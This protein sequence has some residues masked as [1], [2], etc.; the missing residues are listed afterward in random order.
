VLMAYQADDAK[1]AIQV[2]ENGTTGFLEV[3][4]E[5]EQLK[6]DTI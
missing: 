3:K 2:T 4:A 1:S 6:R 5:V